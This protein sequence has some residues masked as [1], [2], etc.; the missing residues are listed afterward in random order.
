MNTVLKGKF[1]EATAIYFL[2]KQYTILDYNFYSRYGEIDIVCFDHN[3]NQLVFVEVKS[4]NAK[5]HIQA[6]ELFSLRKAHKIFRSLH[7]WLYRNSFFKKFNFRID[8]I[9]LTMN[10]YRSTV[11][12]MKHYENIG[13]F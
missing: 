8:L 7:F 2:Q 3:N 6:V 1:A 11:E 13:N 4:T 12:G 5:S 9:T 10:Y